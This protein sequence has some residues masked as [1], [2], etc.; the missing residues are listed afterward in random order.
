MSVQ[1]EFI[2]VVIKKSSVEAKY[3]EGIKA[4]ISS[5]GPF[6]GPV[7]DSD[8][9]LL[10][11]GSMSPDGARFICQFYEAIGLRGLSEDESTWI[12][13]CVVDQLMGP[14]RPCDWLVYDRKSC[15]ATYKENVP[16]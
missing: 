15:T 13:F 4:F 9:Y 8:D 16:S 11:E 10:K 14:T 6:D 1:I 12:D 7:N 5:Y 2:S 3:S